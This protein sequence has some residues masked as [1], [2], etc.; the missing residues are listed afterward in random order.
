MIFTFEILREAGIRLPRPVG[1]QSAIVGALIMGDAAI[2]GRS[3]RRTGGDR[4]G[5][6]GGGR[7]SGTQSERF[8]IL[9]AGFM[10][11]LSASVGYYGLSM[12]FMAV[13]FIS[14]H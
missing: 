10:M 8:G 1:R 6:P 12:G 7:L 14:D 13:R 11:V 4:R 9:T 2:I 5:N 3:G